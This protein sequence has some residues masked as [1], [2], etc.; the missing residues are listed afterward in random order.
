VMR[1]SAERT[2][3][4]ERDLKFFKDIYE[5]NPSILF[6]VDDQFRAT[7]CNKACVDFVGAGD[8]LSL[9]E[10]LTDRIE[11]DIPRHT[12]VDGFTESMMEAIRKAGREG[13]SRVNVMVRV[14]DETEHNISII[15]NKIP[16]EN[17]FV[18]A[19][20]GI[21]VTELHRVKEELSRKD[22]MLDLVNRVTSLLSSLDSA[23][24]ED[25][26]RRAMEI[27]GRAMDIDRIYIWKNRVIDGSLYY[28]PEFV[29][30]RSSIPA[31][32]AMMPDEGFSYDQS[33]PDW[34]E[35]FKR[36]EYVNGPIYTLS[37]TEQERLAPY[38]M[39]SILVIP[40]FFRDKFWGFASIDDCR[41]ERSF[42]EAEVHILRSVTLMIAASLQ[43]ANLKHRPEEALSMT[44]R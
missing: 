3:T 11:A 20:A 24:A 8:K 19:G 36:G 18:L 27:T 43:N 35:L 21:D 29:W 26:I 28:F 9:L 5:L 42:A 4:L 22:K 33:I 17:G 34:E 7:D 38:G 6:L 16:L 44:V 41:K 14:R 37:E 40:L 25:L 1:N 13:S 23:N 30:T 10:E 32:I 12:F 31:N 2:R 39:K 15:Y